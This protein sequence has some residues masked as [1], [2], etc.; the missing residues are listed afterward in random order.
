VRTRPYIAAVTLILVGALA[1][2][3]RT[4][5]GNGTT[6]CGHHL[7]TGAMSILFEPLDATIPGFAW[8]R[9]AA[10]SSKIASRVYAMA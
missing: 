2:C 3:T 6:L 7:D 1:G 5:P 4:Y 8:R 9:A 10:E